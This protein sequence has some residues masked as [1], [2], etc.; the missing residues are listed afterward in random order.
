M[1]ESVA[2][3]WEKETIPNDAFLY[4]R[5][6]RDD[7]DSDGT[8]KPGAFRNRP[9][10]RDGMSTDWEKYSSPEECRRRSKS[11]LDNAVI[12]MLAGDIR[13]LPDQ[14][15]EHSPIYRPEE[16]EERLRFNRAHT[17]VFGPKKESVKIKEK[18]VRIRLLF[19]DIYQFAIKLDPIRHECGLTNE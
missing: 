17:D 13:N 7:I 1:A 16:T 18:S 4:M 6:H 12:Q 8:V 5:V 15:V 10:D 2:S 14:T 3:P 9:T 11:P 19:L